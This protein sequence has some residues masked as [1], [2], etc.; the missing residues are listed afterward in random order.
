M[1]MKIK[2]HSSKLSKKQYQRYAFPRVSRKDHITGTSQEPIQL[3]LERAAV[4]YTEPA[5][6]GFFAIKNF[7]DII[8]RMRSNPEQFGRCLNKLI[9]LFSE[10]VESEG[11]VFTEYSGAGAL[12]AFKLGSQPKAAVQKALVTALKMRYVMNKLNREWDF[13]FNE[14]WQA[15]FGIDCGAVSFSERKEGPAVLTTIEGKSG[16]IAQG[17]GQSAGASQIIITESMYLQFPFLETAFDIKPPKHLPV[18]GANILSK[19]REVVGMV[20]PQAKQI[21]ETY[22]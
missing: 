17:I 4:V 12:F 13:R 9:S 5:A 22:V 3:H 14:A 11:G 7:T 1:V 6:V 10:I 8:E 21:Y 16:V 20:G 2:V 15:G 19:T 18:I